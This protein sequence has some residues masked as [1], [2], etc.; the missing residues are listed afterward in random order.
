MSK[1]YVKSSLLATTMIAGIAFATPAIAQSSAV[2]VEAEP[3]LVEDAPTVDE[4]VA[5]ERGAIVVTGSR[6]SRPNLEQSSPVSVISAEEISL[7]QPQSAEEFLRDLPGS[8][9]GQNAQVNNGNTGIATLNL[10]NLGTNRNLVLLNE[11]RVVPSDLAAQTDLNIIPV[12]LIERVD[13]FTG[14]AS[15]VYG[16]DA[17]AGV[18]NF[19]TKRNFAGIE[20]NAQY[21]ITERGD[22]AN[23][24]LDLTTG[25]NFADGRGNAVISLNYTQSD[26]V[27]AGEREF[28][29]IARSSATGGEQGSPTAVPATITSALF[30]DPVTGAS[31]GNS[32]VDPATGTFVLG[33]SNF[34][35]LP[36][37]ILQ[38]PF[39]R[40]GIFAQ[41][42]FEVSDA[43]E[44]YS[45]GF[46]TRTSVKNRN[47][48]SGSFGLSF[49][50]PLNSPFFTDTQ[51]Q[52]VCN[53]R[54]DGDPATPGLQRPSPA[55]CDAAIAA[56]TEVSLATARRFTEAGPRITDSR[57]NT[58]ELVVGARGPLTSTL[59]WDISAQRGKADR[60]NAST[61]QGLASRLQE[62]VRGCPTGSTSGC[63]PINLFGAEGS[64]TPEQVAFLDVP[65]SAFINT[66]FDA[67]QAVING[68]LGFSSPLASEAIGIALGAEYRKYS[69]A[70]RGDLPSSTSGAVLGAGAPSLPVSGSYNTKELFAEIVIPL[71]EERF[72]HNLTVE[73][74]ARYSDYSTSGG[75]WTYKVGGSFMPIPDIKLRGIYSRAVRAPNIGEL[76]QPQVTFLTARGVDPCQ[77]TE[78]QIAARGASVAVCKAAT[79]LAFGGVPAPQ[80]GQINATTGGNPALDPEIATTLTAGVVLQPRFVPGFAVTLDYYDIKVADA[81][82]NP[83]AADII[84]ACFFGNNSPTLLAC[85]LIGR[86]PDNGSLSGPNATTSGPFLGLSNLGAIRSSGFD[87]GASYR[88][89]LGFARLALSFVGNKTTRSLFQA[90]PSSIN[91][92]CVGFF[93]P[94][95][96]APTPKYTFNQRTTLSIGSS[97]FSVLWRHISSN[98]VEPF[99]AAADQVFG[100]KPT[101]QGPS[102][103]FEP[104]SK[105]EAY[106]YFDFAYQQM[107]GRTM[108]LTFT[109]SNLFDKQP[110]FVGGQ[111]GG[112]GSQSSATNTFPTLYD[113][114]GRR[115]TMG[116]NLRF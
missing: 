67:A 101:T 43:V 98:R 4:A 63:I 8:T 62:A 19:I 112:G 68:D 53:A 73:A 94:G 77:G 55:Q 42:R 64:I 17:I 39:E 95:C 69:G 20:A 114:L 2:P 97:D 66:E 56:G 51:R 45:Q 81:I 34:N 32:R 99:V 22:G 14:G 84:D 44:L 11:R 47:A 18:I 52:I 76:F 61:G 54:L 33:E 31:L 103:F 21:G 106:N 13:I 100:G 48:P 115:F 46:F 50:F 59:N 37:T 9:P 83:T 89:D 25:A 28:G 70:S 109:V 96:G 57:S 74:G 5:G 110:P 86:N 60:V 10:R 75:N 65:T 49:F 3:D 88:R 29:Q 93:S 108:K 35:F 26:A 58:F 79:G 92:D 23:Y 27:V 40:Y 38:T 116:A 24:R 30:F 82:S 6:I 36:I 87:L 15:T 104:F 111:A 72:I 113:P 1:S 41:G 7:V 78:A 12:A 71:I 105:I 85:T 80:A 16:A 107:I 90:T 91:R 102:N